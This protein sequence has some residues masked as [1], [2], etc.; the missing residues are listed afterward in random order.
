VEEEGR[1]SITIPGNIEEHCSSPSESTRKTQRLR[2]KWPWLSCG[3]EMRR[4]RRKGKCSRQ[5]MIGRLR[6][7]VKIVLIERGG[8]ICLGRLRRE[9]NDGKLC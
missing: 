8:R 1:G 2:F 6:E 7:L 4:G 9:K 5:L 3:K